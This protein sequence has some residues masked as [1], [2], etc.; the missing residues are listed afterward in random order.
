LTL[1]QP[2]PV[3]PYER[4]S[5]VRLVPTTELGSALATPH[6]DPRDRHF[7]RWIG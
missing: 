3:C 2:V 4:T 7:Q 1:C 6:F 5:L